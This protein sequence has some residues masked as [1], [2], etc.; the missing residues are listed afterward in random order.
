MT[1]PT[2]TGYSH[3]DNGHLVHFPLLWIDGQWV[4]V[5]GPWRDRVVSEMGP[6]SFFSLS[7]MFKGCKIPNI[8]CLKRIVFEYRKVVC[9]YLFLRTPRSATGWFFPPFNCDGCV[10]V[11]VG[12][13]GD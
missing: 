4:V 11:G 1:C 13:L 9:L 6:F 7:C 12:G 2:Y 10:G 3:N 8:P 5:C